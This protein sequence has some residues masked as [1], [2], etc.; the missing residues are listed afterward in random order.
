MSNGLPWI[1]RG[2]LSHRR[3]IEFQFPM[4]K[5]NLWIIMII[6]LTLLLMAIVIWVFDRRIEKINA[7]MKSS[8]VL[9]GIKQKSLKS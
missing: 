5:K 1:Y 4:L 8:A 3:K 6:L 2:S 9:S 7:R